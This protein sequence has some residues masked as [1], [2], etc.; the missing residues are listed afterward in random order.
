MWAAVKPGGVIVVEDAD[1]DAAIAYP[2]NEGHDFWVDTYRRVL[3]RHGGDPQAGRKL[4][5]HFGDADIPG[6]TIRL[7]QRVD[8]VGEEKKL[9]MLTLDATA[10][11]IVA[12]GIASEDEVQRA[13]ASLAEI[14]DDTTTIVL[15]PQ[16]FQLWSRRE[17][18][19]G[20]SRPETG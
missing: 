2:S 16:V 10:G 4:Y 19:A 20:T 8:I 15:S 18:S 14:S 3:E 11:A 17:S 13:R 7:R 5:A 1:F 9:P 6:P 12:E